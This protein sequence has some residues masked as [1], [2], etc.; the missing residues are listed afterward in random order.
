M[1]GV[2]GDERHLRRV[3]RLVRVAGGGAEQRPRAC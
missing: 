3:K 1:S 2:A